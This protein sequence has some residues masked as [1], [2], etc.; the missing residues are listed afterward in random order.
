MTLDDYQTV[1]K[2]ESVRAIGGNIIGHGESRNQQLL[3]GNT[4]QIDGNLDAHGMYGVTRVLHRWTST[5]YVNEFLCTP[6]KDYTNPDPPEANSWYGLVPARVVAHN[7]PKKMGR[8]QVQYYWQE[9]STAHWA[10][11]VTPHS[12]ADRG[13]MFMPEVGDEVVVAFEDGDIERPYVLG[14]VWNGVDQAPRQGFWDKAEAVDQNSDL[15]ENDVK[16]IVTK[17]GHRLQ[18]VDK[19]GKESIAMATPNYL[20]LSMI[21]KTDETGRSMITLHSENGDIFL[22]APNGR[23]HLLSKY[24][25]R[26]VGDEAVPQPEEK[27]E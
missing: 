11:M 12:G 16:R 7:D 17:S 15:Q 8:I 10:R 5:G 21:E 25:S 24:F 26:E 6:W 9:D 27:R 3:P 18:F 14:G 22:S 19:Q 4:V 1:L 2:K 13:F 20:K 23:I